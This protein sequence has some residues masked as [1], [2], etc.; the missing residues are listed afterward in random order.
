M[1]NLMNDPKTFRAFVQRFIDEYNKQ[2]SNFYLDITELKTIG[3]NFE[4]F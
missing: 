3:F 4:T 2:I 1:K